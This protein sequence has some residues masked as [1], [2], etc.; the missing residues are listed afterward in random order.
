MR[1]LSECFPL[2]VG[3]APSRYDADAIRRMSEAFEPYFVRGERYAYVSIQLPD[4]SHPG[5]V[6]RKLL[7]DW[8]ELPRVREHA[9][10]LCVGAAAVVDGTLMR[11]ALTALLWFWKPPF[12]L[13]TMRTSEEGISFCLNRLVAAKLVLPEAVPGMKARAGRMLGAALD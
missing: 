10:A 12:P 4:A 6:E 1:L 9:A 3:I 8:V 13:E 5:A 7:M 11:G 2:L